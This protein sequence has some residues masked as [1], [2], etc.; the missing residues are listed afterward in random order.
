[1]PENA[2]GQRSPQADGEEISNAWERIHQ[3]VV[4]NAMRQRVYAALMEEKRF[5]R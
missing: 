4:F 1:M 5:T 2:F 3:E